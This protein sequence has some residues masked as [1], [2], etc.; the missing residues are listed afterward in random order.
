[1]KVENMNLLNFIKK[2]L[3]KRR[4]LSIK[5][6]NLFNGMS[7]KFQVLSR[8]LIQNINHT[9]SDS[10]SEWFVLRKIE[11]L[12][13]IKTLL[14]KQKNGYQHYSYFD[15]YPYQAFSTLG[16]FGERSTEERYKQYRIDSYLDSSH[17]VLDL[18]CN[19]GFMGIYTS[20]RKGCSVTGIDINPYAIE[21][22]KRCVEFLDLNEKVNLRAVTVQDLDKSKKYNALFSFATHWTDDKNYR[23]PLENHFKMIHDLLEHEGLLFFES[24]SVDVG[25]E[26]FYQI[27]DS[28][29]SLFQTLYKID[30][31][32]K[33]RHYYIFK[34][35]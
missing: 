25:N 17:S 18:G 24:H 2:Q 15:G 10:Q 5:L 31:D 29:Q 19:C 1:M 33:S 30:T 20:Y 8:K 11:L 34:K 14:Q 21:I 7:V 3:R 35:I 9:S 27:I 16:I 12:N 28:M 4:L 26:Q 32:A 6:A 22:G 23:V 13:D